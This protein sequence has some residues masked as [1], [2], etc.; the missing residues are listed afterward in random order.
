MERPVTVPEGDIYNDTD[1]EWLFGETNENN[2]GVG[3]WNIWHIEGYHRVTI[4]YRDGTPPYPTQRFH[5]DGT[6]S[7]DGQWYGGARY[8]GPVRLIKSNHPTPEHFPAN[9][10][11]N[12]WIAEFDYVDEHLYNAQRY[13]DRDNNSV[14]SDGDPLPARPENVPA[15]AHFVRLPHATAKWVMGTVDIRIGNYIGE[16]V[17]WDQDG[18]LLIQKLYSTGNRVLEDHRYEFDGALS[19]SCLYDKDDPNKSESYFY[20]SGTTTPVVKIRMTH[21]NGEKDVTNLYFDK[22]GQ[23][24]YSIRRE[25]LSPVHKRRYFNGQL[26]L[27]GHLSPQ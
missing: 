11:D 18:K 8:V 3:R 13:F 24:L 25:Q 17:E 2:Q 14:S 27:E 22:T 16:Y 12:V 21:R 26:V 7:Q 9:N 15:R 6:V 23:E 4:D 1:K 20:Y 19:S 10:G 5:P